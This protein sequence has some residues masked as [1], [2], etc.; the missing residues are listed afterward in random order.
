MGES[1]GMEMKWVL[2]RTQVHILKDKVFENES[3]FQN[4][5]LFSGKSE[6]IIYDA[7]M[8]AGRI[9]IGIEFHQGSTLKG[10]RC[11]LCEGGSSGADREV[12]KNSPNF[13]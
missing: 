4:F 3:Q 12:F 1:P 2:E 11:L 7:V 8:S 13:E 10:C 6:V 9:L 5:Q